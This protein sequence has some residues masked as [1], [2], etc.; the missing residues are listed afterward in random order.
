[1]AV[2]DR[3]QVGAYN[4]ANNATYDFKAAAA[5]EALLQL[6]QSQSGKTI[7]VYWTD[8]GTN[9]VLIETLVGGSVQYSTRVSDTSYV[10]VKNVSGGTAG[11]WAIGVVTK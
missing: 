11:V 9:F 4:V 8:D 2:G 7:E 1:M 3:L 10:R 6:I 5:G